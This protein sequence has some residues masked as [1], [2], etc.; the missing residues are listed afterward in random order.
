MGDLG[1]IWTDDFGDGMIVQGQAR[2][3][4]EFADAYANCRMQHTRYGLW[5]AG[6]G[7]YPDP[8]E[9]WRV[10]RFIVR[11]ARDPDYPPTPDELA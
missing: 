3:T 11:A 5:E 10:C 4:E 6:Y 9:H 1:W 8:R 7:H 2:P